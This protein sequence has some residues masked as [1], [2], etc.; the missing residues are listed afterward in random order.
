MAVRVVPSKQLAFGQVF[1]SSI[2]QAQDR[3]R[4]FPVRRDAFEPKHFQIGLWSLRER[5]LTAELN[6]KQARDVHREYTEVSSRFAFEPGFRKEICFKRLQVN[7]LDQDEGRIALFN[8][9]IEANFL[10]VPNVQLL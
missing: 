4:T 10:R 1:A 5:Q 2:R 3:H 9:I 7:V 8:L 6:L